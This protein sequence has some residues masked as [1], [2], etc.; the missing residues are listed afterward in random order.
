M[1]ATSAVAEL[2]VN[3]EVTYLLSCGSSIS[4]LQLPSIRFIKNDEFL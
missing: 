4:L 3:P 1:R 2:L